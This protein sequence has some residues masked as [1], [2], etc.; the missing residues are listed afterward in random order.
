MNHTM[1]RSNVY[2]LP[3]P[4][5]PEV[6]KPRSRWTSLRASLFRGWW[7]LRITVAE[8]RSVVCRPGRRLAAPG[9]L[10]A[11]DPEANAPVSTRRPLGPARIIDFEAARLRLRPAAEA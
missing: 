3:S 11:L 8:I 5:T 7:R 6:I 10:G 9:Y 2:Y 1:L 4:I